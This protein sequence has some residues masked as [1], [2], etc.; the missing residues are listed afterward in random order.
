VYK[1]LDIPIFLRDTAYM[2]YPG[3]KGSVYKR[4][5]NLMPPHEVY[6]ET[7]LGG[8][9]IMR[10][11]RPA[12]RNIGIE[13]DPKIIDLWRKREPL[14]FELIQDDALQYL[15]GY[16]FT[17]KEL[18]YCDPPYLRETR[19]KSKKLYR[20]EYTHEQHR[21]LLELLC[22]LPC[23]V[24]LSGYE[25]ALYTEYLRGWH[26][27]WYT[28]GCHH[29]T[30]VEWVWMNYP[31]PVELHDYRYLGNNFREREKLKK[32]AKKWGRRLQSLPVLERQALF[33][34]LQAVKEDN[35]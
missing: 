7:H 8:G 3:G 11:K 15:K 18:I 35:G 33:I 21:A 32:R 27:H 5:I 9:S 2:K 14:E 23:R 16:Q 10:N 31:A 30:A 17:G 29:G 6:I 26:T 4:L 22:S 13:I 19:K 25:S 1:G 12:Q 28:V 34:A 24:M 20:Y